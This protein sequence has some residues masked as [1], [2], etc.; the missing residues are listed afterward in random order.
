M[1]VLESWRERVQKLES[2]CALERG[3]F[4]REIGKLQ[5]FEFGERGRPIVQ[6]PSVRLESKRI[7]HSIAL[8]SPKL[9]LAYALS[10]S[11]IIK[12]CMY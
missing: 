11:K 1:R 4:E 8:S 3:E 9:R 10:F 7:S 12:Q 5:A 2:E 6:A